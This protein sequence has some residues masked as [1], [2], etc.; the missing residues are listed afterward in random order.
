MNKII[1]LLAFALA[2]ATAA[3]AHAQVTGTSLPN[4]TTLTSGN[5]TTT[6]PFVY[7][8]G[9][10]LGVRKVTIPDLM[11]FGGW[12]PL[13]TGVLTGLSLTGGLVSTTAQ[14]RGLLTTSG[15]T[16]VTSSLTT[17][18]ASGIG[19]FGGL[20]STTAQINGLLTTTG[21]IVTNS[22]TISGLLT[23]SGITS[24][25]GT[26]S[27]T[28]TVSGLSSM[29]T[30]SATTLTLSGLSTL[31]TLVST[32]GTITNLVGTTLT[33]GGNTSLTGAVQIR[34][35][36]ENF[37]RVDMRNAQSTKLSIGTVGQQYVSFADTTPASYVSIF[38]G[39]GI[40]FSKD[41]GGTL[42]GIASTA[43]GLLKIT[44]GT[45]TSGFGT[46][47]TGGFIANIR[48]VTTDTTNITLTDSTITVTNIGAVTLTLPTA[49]SRT[50]QVYYMKN[51]GAVAA[52]VRTVSSQT[53]DGISTATILAGSALG[54]QSDGTNYIKI[55]P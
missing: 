29:T 12:G 33:I 6:S 34:G 50:G 8:D 1:K 42:V 44:N 10:G 28:L 48:D 45:T 22:S 7:T 49:V 43:D 47:Q 16:S 53:I 14:I 37:G 17:L 25:T 3:A 4:K 5:V 36:L 54:V 24:A 13:D 9:V 21:G 18:T 31:P 32:T 52:T 55:T 27:G 15:V 51:K 19:T 20:V 46:I 38:G 2:V 11:D 26:I 41:T 35:Y 30:L 23:T 40:G 39:Y